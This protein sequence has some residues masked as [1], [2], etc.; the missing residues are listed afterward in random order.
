MSDNIDDEVRAVA[1]EIVSYLRAHPDA[2]DTV[3]GAARWWLR[4]RTQSETLDRA[5]TLLVNQRIVEKHT[6]PEGTTVFRGG[7]MLVPPERSR[8]PES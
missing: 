7:P 6:L 2:A 5:V 3:E 8:D 4:R 1:A